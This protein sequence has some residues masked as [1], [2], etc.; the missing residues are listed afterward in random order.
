M[1][2]SI[3]NIYF[4]TDKKYSLDDLVFPLD[5]GVTIVQIREKNVSYEEFLKRAKFLKKECFKRNIPLIV[6]DNIDIAININADGLHVGQDDLNIEE[7]R[8]KF[9]NKI[10]GVSVTTLEEALIVERNNADYIGVG[11][12]FSTNTK[13]DAKYVSI[14]QL[15][16]IIESVNIPVIA[17]GGITSKNI[18]KIIDFDLH[19]LAISEGLLKSKLEL[20]EIIKKYEWNI[21][22]K[23]NY[24]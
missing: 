10:I 2:K 24:S 4:V 18:D 17:I 19:G 21:K 8:K 12:I 9:P 11:S 13:R 16:K 20:K 14:K 22:K 15:K 7:C 23:Y 3:Y 5:H 6:N 1:K